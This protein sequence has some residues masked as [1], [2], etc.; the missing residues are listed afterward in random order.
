MLAA[1]QEAGVL[2]ALDRQLAQTLMRLGGERDERVGVAAAL[3][4]RSVREGRTC[5]DLSA[6]WT[7]AAAFGAEPRTPSVAWPEPAA[8]RAALAASPLQGAE[9][10]ATPLHLDGGGRLYFRRHL[11]HERRLAAALARRVAAGSSEGSAA[12]NGADGLRRLFGDAPGDLQRRAA[13]TALAQRFCIVTGGPG[14]GKTATVA[15]I[16]ALWI[17]GALDAG[18]EAPRVLLLAPTGKAAARLGEAIRRAKAQLDCSDAVRAAIPEQA[19]TLH[20]AL[21]I[22]PRRARV[23]YDRERPLAV[24]AVVVD[25]ASMVDL[26]LM[27]RLFDA[28][29]EECRCLLLGDKDQLASVEAGAVLG[30]LCAAA[31]DPRSSAGFASAVVELRRSYRYAED[32]GIRL[33]ADAVNRADADEALRILRDPG[34]PDVRLEAPASGA[35]IPRGVI[36]RALEAFACLRS[37]GSPAEKLG[38]LDSFRVLCAHQHGLDGALAV[39]HAVESALRRR[40]ELRG[41]PVHYAGRPILVTRNDP[42]AGLFN[43]DA[44]VIEL[45]AAGW[46]ALFPAAEGGVRA[47][48]AARL[49]AHESVHAM[50]VHKSQGSEFDR[51]A[52]LLP[53]QPSPV[54]T[55]ELLY[56]AITRARREVVI[57]AS[58][59]VLRQTIATAL[60]RASGLRDRLITR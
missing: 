2:S 59:A 3:L 25:E 21:G 52:I 47:L 9:D 15:K 56:T 54:S 36:D 60:R 39:N 50:S 12:D 32:S 28:L 27:D 13:Q 4:S 49:P 26:A 37:A 10:A 41:D 24:D 48:A 6:P 51:V 1:L 34:L 11:E 58:E 38:T 55:R 44:G 5:L 45:G 30:D 23:R 22:D 43:G 31:A 8:W 40:G 35:P 57:H 19:G 33:L 14:T 18:R 42:G 53:A 46:R 17:E 29:P 16:L 20:R 7:V